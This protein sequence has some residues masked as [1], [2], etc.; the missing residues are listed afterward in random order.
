M[1]VDWQVA[2]LAFPQPKS[3]L[4]QQFL[5]SGCVICQLVGFTRNGERSAS[6]M[7]PTE[8][9]RPASTSGFFLKRWRAYRRSAD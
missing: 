4:F 5:R 1:E 8:R 2:M 7:L 9:T 3:G 6:A